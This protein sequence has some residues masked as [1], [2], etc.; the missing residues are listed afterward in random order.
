MMCV[1]SYPGKQERL[2]QKQ[3][4]H[5]WAVEMAALEKEKTADR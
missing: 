1:N 4:I 5:L 3:G 2:M